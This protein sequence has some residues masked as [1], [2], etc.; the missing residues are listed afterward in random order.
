MGLSKD[1]KTKTYYKRGVI[2][3]AK[4]VFRR[5]M[6]NNVNSFKESSK[7]GSWKSHHNEVGWRERS[8]SKRNED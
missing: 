3:V 7:V 4:R 5:A 6:G 8:L 1:Y 2:D